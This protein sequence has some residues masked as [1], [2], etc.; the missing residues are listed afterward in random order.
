MLGKRRKG[1]LLRADVQRDVIGSG[2]VGGSAGFV[3]HHSRSPAS[4][5]SSATGMNTFGGT[6]AAL[7]VIPADQCFE[8]DQLCD[9]ALTTL[10]HQVELPWTRSP[11][12][13]RFQANAVF[14]LATAARTRNSGRNR[15]RRPSLGRAQGRP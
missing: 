4:G 1:D 7:R 2:H 10:E 8:A 9:L 14:L 5:R 12:E 15:G 3:D 11:G 6:K 13:G